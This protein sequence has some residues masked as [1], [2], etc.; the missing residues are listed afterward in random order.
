MNRMLL[1]KRL[2]TQELIQSFRPHQVFKIKLNGVAPDQRVMV[3]TS[4]FISIAIVIF[5]FSL[6]VVSLIEPHL[7]FESVIGAVTGCLFN[8][9][10]GF[11]AVGPT[12][13]YADLNRSTMVFLSILMAMG[14]LEFFAVLVLF[15]PS[16]WRKY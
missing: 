14:R 16:L 10:P 2:V 9:G 12:D 7:D 5:G 3:Q 6:I 1:L 13:T 8:I 11:G 4:M 15:I